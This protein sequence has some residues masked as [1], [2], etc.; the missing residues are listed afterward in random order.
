MQI[1]PQQGPLH[2]MAMPTF[3]ILPS[4][5]PAVALS[6]VLRQNQ[7][8]PLA[9]DIL[10]MARYAPL[11]CLSGFIHM[12][13]NGQWGSFWNNYFGRMVSNNQPVDGENRGCYRFGEHLMADINGVMKVMDHTGLIDRARR[14]LGPLEQEVFDMASFFHATSTL[15]NISFSQA[16][17]RSMVQARPDIL[18]HMVQSQQPASFVPDPLLARTESGTDQ[19]GATIPEKQDISELIFG[20]GTPASATL[21][22]QIQPGYE[23]MTIRTISQALKHFRISDE[24]MDQIRASTKMDLTAPSG[25]KTF[26]LAE[27][28]CGLYNLS[29]SAS[30]RR[31]PQ[32]VG[33]LSLAL[34]DYE[35]YVQPEDTNY[36]PKAL[37]NMIWSLVVH[38]GY[39]LRSDRPGSETATGLIV[40]ANIFSR[41]VLEQYSGKTKTAISN[42]LHGRIT[43][44][45]KT[46]TKRWCD[47]N[48]FSTLIPLLLR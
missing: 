40:R 25:G 10:P 36:N 2:S 4:D 26:T 30:N 47:L 18:R 16:L 32:L 28:L 39:N 29:Y 21:I 45:D 12:L 24:R 41:L 43:I 14:L 38:C 11:E 17:G 34:F 15:P 1:K 37:A 8:A 33:A 3:E 35:N 20:K 5:H 46:P 19:A 27:V 44:A 42:S 31:E 23:S 48:H 6:L 22:E 9:I 13:R 7:V